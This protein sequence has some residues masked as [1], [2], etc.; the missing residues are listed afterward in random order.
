M[1]HLKYFQYFLSAILER[2]VFFSKKESSIAK[3]EQFFVEMVS[4]VK[5]KVHPCTGTTAL[6][7]PYDP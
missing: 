3:K 7:R 1:E 4:K 2:H 5:V 6:Y